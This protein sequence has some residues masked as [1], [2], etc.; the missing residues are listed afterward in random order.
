MRYVNQALVQM[1]GYSA[2]E[3]SADSL[4]SAAPQRDE[5]RSI[6]AHC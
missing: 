3:W 1:M 4:E 6:H 5:R 2:E